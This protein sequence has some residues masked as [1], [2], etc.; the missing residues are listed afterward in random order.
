MKNKS[1]GKLRKRR[2]QTLFSLNI[3]SGEVSKVKVE[4]DTNI[5]G[6]NGN[7]VVNY[8]ASI[9]EKHPLIWALNL[10][11]AVRKFRKMYG[12]KNLSNE[13]FKKIKK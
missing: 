7:D 11:N 3:E 1:I 2:G 8:K 6:K 5:V 13:E 12:L 10:K 9:N 4:I